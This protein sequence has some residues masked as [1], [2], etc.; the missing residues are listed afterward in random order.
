MRAAQNDSASVLQT[1]GPMYQKK[2]Q[3][4]KRPD[5]T[6]TDLYFSQPRTS[7]NFRHCF[8]SHT[9]LSCESKESV[10]NSGRNYGLLKIK[11]LP[12]DWWTR[13][14]RR[15]ECH[16]VDGSTVDSYPCRSELAPKSP[17]L[18]NRLSKQ[19]PYRPLYITLFSR[20][21]SGPWLKPGRNYRFLNKRPGP[22]ERAPPH[23]IEVPAFNC[24]GGHKDRLQLEM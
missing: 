13:Y 4:T 18:A 24:G 8:D 7:L 17:K 6:V 20:L 11:L 5:S 15:I 16:T 3:K 22:L 2:K 10:W 14:D 12:T 1:F 9:P 21:N 19:T 23:L